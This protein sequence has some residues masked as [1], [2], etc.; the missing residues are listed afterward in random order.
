MAFEPGCFLMGSG[1]HR[2]SWVRSLGNQHNRHA[3]VKE[4]DLWSSRS[5]QAG[6]ETPAL[7]ELQGRAG[8]GTSFAA[9]RWELEPCILILLLCDVGTCLAL[10][11]LS[12]L[13]CK[14]GTVWVC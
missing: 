7:Q 10:P 6:G 4:A 2:G 13:I 5:T 9:G 8:P 1:C 12:F 11:S 3:E 14:T